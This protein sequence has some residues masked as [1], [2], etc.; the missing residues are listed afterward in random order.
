MLPLRGGAKVSR[1]NQHERCESKDEGTEAELPSG[2]A[3]A[4]LTKNMENFDAICTMAASRETV[5]FSQN[6]HGYQ[7]YALMPQLEELSK[8]LKTAREIIDIFPKHT[9]T[10]T[11]ICQV[12]PP[13]D[14]DP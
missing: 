7:T 6:S 8:T 9:V 4:P 1:K 10:W 5:M 12:P 13:C 11:A 3:P 2:F 14:C